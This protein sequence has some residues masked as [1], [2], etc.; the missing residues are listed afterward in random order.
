MP[1]LNGVKDMT[2]RFAVRVFTFLFFAALLNACSSTQ[3]PR[4]PGNPDPLV[5]GVVTG[6]KTLKCDE[7]HVTHRPGMTAFPSDGAW[8]TKNL[9]DGLATFKLYSSRTFDALNTDIGQPDGAS[10]LCLGCHDGSYPGVGGERMFGT[11]NLSH[12]HPVSFTYSSSLAA[13]VPRN[14]L[15]DPSITASGLGGTIA[16]DL[17]DDQD[18]L[19]CTSCHDVH[20][21]G[22]IRKML[23]FEFGPSSSSGDRLCVVCHNM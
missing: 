20:G 15:R 14:K 10:R 6:H 8:S 23:R 22:T 1:T 19:Q 21:K 11:S 7:C 12:T 2:R 5:K 3:K 13:R 9:S 18:K 4:G 17:L 16:K